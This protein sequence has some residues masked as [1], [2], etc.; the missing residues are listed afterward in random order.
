MINIQI[1]KDVREYQP[2]FI[3]SFTFRQAV[4]LAIVV[5]I[6]SAAVFVQKNILGMETVNYIPQMII[7]IIPLFFGWGEEALHMKPESYIRTVF[8]NMFFIPKKRVFK[9][10]NYYDVYFSVEEEEEPYHEKPL[11]KKD[12]KNLD[13]EFVPYQ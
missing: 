10:R 8:K 7:S 11:K 4:C 3:G 1:P 12:L 13:P 9:S 2:K 5:A 6:N